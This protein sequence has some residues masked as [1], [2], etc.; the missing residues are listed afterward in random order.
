M[1]TRDYNFNQFMNDVIKVANEQE[2][3]E[4]LFD[5]KN[6]EVIGIITSL[7]NSG[8]WLFIA[9]VALLLLGPIGLGAAIIAFMS[10]PT[11]W[12]VA[13]IFGSAAAASIW[14]LY[15]DKDLPLAVKEVGE[16]FKPKWEKVEGNSS[17][18]NSLLQEAVIR[19]I[20]KTRKLKEEKIQEIKQQLT[21]KGY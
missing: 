18:V 16:E 8:W 11:G 10:T 15:K 20:T 3:L 12:A 17:K 7:I 2:D 4:N 9:V 1:A 6:K 13:A 5:V 21:K 19:L 14:T